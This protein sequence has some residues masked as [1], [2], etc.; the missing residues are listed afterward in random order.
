MYAATKHAVHAVGEGLRMELAPDRIRVT[1]V[2]PGFVRTGI[3]DGWPDGPL[4]ERYAG[5]MAATA[6][7]PADVAAAV[8]HVLGL[9]AGV[10]VHEYAVTSVEQ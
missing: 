7:D 3:L 10:A 8:V 4:R 6:L 5:A 1:T 9:P 2:A